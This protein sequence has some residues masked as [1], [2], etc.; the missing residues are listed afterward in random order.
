MQTHKHLPTTQF[1]ARGLLA[2]CV[3]F[4][5]PLWAADANFDMIGDA[6]QEQLGQSTTV[7]R[8]SLD[9]QTNY[10]VIHPS[11]P[12]VYA[13]TQTAC[14]YDDGGKKCWQGSSS[15]LPRSTA[16]RS[17]TG[18]FAAS[19]TSS[20]TGIYA[21][22]YSCN[23]NTDMS[24]IC[25]IQNKRHA[26]AISPSTHVDSGWYSDTSASG[27]VSGNL[28]VTLPVKAVQIMANDQKLCAITTNDQQNLACWTPSYTGDDNVS[29]VGIL[30]TSFNMTPYTPA[31]TPFFDA[32]LDGLSNASDSDDDNDGVPDSLDALPYDATEITQSPLPLDNS[33]KGSS[34]QEAKTPQ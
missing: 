30:V 9:L 34:V 6:W 18:H 24:V 3:L 29:Q 11:L 31:I 33:Y 32:D 20:C 22:L 25:T 13:I 19:C 23:I 1:L 15:A 27:A 28:S 12:Y 2:I 7:P 17:T 5:L 14:A 16:T 26:R 10:S 21:I 8:Y 4:S